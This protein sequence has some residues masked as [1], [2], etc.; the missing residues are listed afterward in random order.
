M[1]RSSTVASILIFANI[2][3]HVPLAGNYPARL[4]VEQLYGYMVRNG[5]VYGVLSTMKGWSFLRRDNGGRLYMTR[6][7]GDFEAWQGL[8]DGA[9]AEGLL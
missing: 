8:S 6:M 5:K 7:F 3:D 1:T 4:A 9:V 2:V